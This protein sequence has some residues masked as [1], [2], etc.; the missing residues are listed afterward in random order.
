MSCYLVVEAPAQR[1]QQLTRQLGAGSATQRA[2]VMHLGD[3]LCVAPYIPRGRIRCSLCTLTPT[4]PSHLCQPMQ[5]VCCCCSTLSCLV[6]SSYQ[7]DSMLVCRS[8]S[9]ITPTLPRHRTLLPAFSDPA[10]PADSCMGKLQPPKVHLLL[11]AVPDT[12][13]PVASCLAKVQPPHVHHIVLPAL[14][15]RAQ[16]VDLQAVRAERTRCSS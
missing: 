9:P 7:R 15:Q 6:S 11:P 4:L 8:P 16:A 1:R 10:Q 2:D 13:Q 5:L 3:Q 12:A 14:P